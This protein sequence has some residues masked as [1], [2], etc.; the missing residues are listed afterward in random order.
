MLLCSLRYD[1][2]SFRRQEKFRTS[3]GKQIQSNDSAAAKVLYLS[4][5]G[6]SA[7][8]CEEGSKDVVRM[9]AISGK[10]FNISQGHISQ[11]PP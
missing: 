1:M 3:I 2:N 10:S 4:A 8:L 6:T 9:F 11:K 5:S 7:D